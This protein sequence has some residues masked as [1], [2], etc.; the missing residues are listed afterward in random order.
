MCVHY[1][2]KKE[3]G[4]IFH[5]NRAAKFMVEFFFQDESYYM[6]NNLITVC[7]LCVSTTVF[8]LPAC[9]YLVSFCYVITPLLLQVN[10]ESK[11][12]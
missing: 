9:L 3:S 2:C 7:K 8:V 1:Y 5:S 6:E 10:E 12:I 11:Q 4:G